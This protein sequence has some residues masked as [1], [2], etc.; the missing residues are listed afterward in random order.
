MTKNTTNIDAD[1]DDFVGLP[2]AQP[3]VE[4]AEVEWNGKSTK[5]R[6]CRPVTRDLRPTGPGEKC[7]DGCDTTDH[8]FH[9]RASKDSA[10]KWHGPEADHFQ[11]LIGLGV[12]A[13]TTEAQERTERQRRRDEMVGPTAS[14]EMT[15]EDQRHKWKFELTADGRRVNTNI[16]SGLRRDEAEALRTAVREGLREGFAERD[17]D[18]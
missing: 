17:K 12:I 3:V 7:I 9:I 2:Y 10:G 11:D 4:K 5:V 13:N 1:L 18:K 14:P 8:Q 15:L 6:L 16:E